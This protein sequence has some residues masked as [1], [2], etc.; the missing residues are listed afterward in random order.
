MSD[1]KKSL[2]IIGSVFGDYSRKKVFI[3]AWENCTHAELV[4]IP[5]D[6]WRVWR[7]AWR[8]F[9]YGWGKDYVL[10]MQVAQ[11]FVLPVLIFRIFYHG[12]IIFDAHISIF[13]TYVNDRQ[14]T[15]R[16]SLKAIYY[17]L[18][19]WLSC[20][21]SD[22]LIFDTLGHQ[23]YFI[24]TFHLTKVKNK[25]FLV[26]PVA[27]DW[28]DL[29]NLCQKETKARENFLEGKYHILF[30]GYYIPLQ[31]VEYILGAANYLRDEERV[32][33]TLIGSG[34]TKKQMLKLAEKLKLTNVTFLP[35]I[36]YEELFGYVNL[37][38]ICLGIFGGTDKAR[39]VVPNKMVEAMACGKI[40]LT[41]R[42]QEMD[43]FFQ[44]GREVVFCQLANAENL[45]QKIMEVCKYPDKFRNLGERAKE[46]IKKD[47]S[48]ERQI[49]IIKNFL[50]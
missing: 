21:V 35:A 39:R 41:G 40:L 15:S 22:I 13:D 48:R 29:D 32:H 44:D 37:A 19:D 8:L 11:F 20:W 6:H 2:L 7:F 43:K 24:K 34:Q 47:F 45:A 25:K 49:E 26:I 4:E 31:G 27:V 38:D 10:V 30:W 23:N 18:I 17:Y 14:L 42:N 36:D 33:F 28:A 50:Q 5:N 12:Q 46:A 3:D 9:R 1:N 16:Y